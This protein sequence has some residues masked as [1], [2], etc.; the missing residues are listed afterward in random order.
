[1][2]NAYL[3][4][5]AAAA[6]A[7]LAAG[8]AMAADTVV[9]W[10]HIEHTERIV[11]NWEAVAEAFEKAH[12]GVD[13][14]LSFLENE[15]YKAKAPTLL[16]SNDRPHLIYSWGGGVM[17]EQADA[18]VIEDIT[19]VVGAQWQE[20]L[21]PAAVEAFTYKGRIWGGPMFVSQVGFWY[22]R[23]LFAK[24]GVDAEAIEDW[25]DLLAAVNTFKE[26]GITPISVGGGDKW[27]LHFYWT[28]L[29]MRTGGRDAFE[30]AV[31]CE[32]D[33]FAAEPFVRAGEL[34]QQLTELEPFQRG[35][36]A[37]KFQEA[38]GLF[39]DGNAA[40]HLM[41]NWDYNMQKT[42]SVSGKGL[43]D[44]RLGWF[45]FPQVEGGK[46]APGDTLGGVNGWLVTKGAPPETI[47]FLRFF[48][49]QENQRM[50]GREDFF[51]PVAVGAETDLKNPYYRRIAENIAASEYHQLFYDQMLGPDV[52][53]VVN[54]ISADL[55]TGAMTPQEAAET[56]QDAWSLDHC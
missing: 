39:G 36:V 8:P 14:Q 32:G 50:M 42:Q 51:I 35:Y 34:F 54:D 56:V 12:P 15:A 31:A 41:G 20:T 37:H 43:D 4:F 11:E 49:S 9:K 29:A 19:D 26:A 2:R 27:P 33:G 23:E 45:P 3:G 55:A 5:G 53:R 52:G 17:H 21:S 47:E 18:G 46:G 22:N 24:A 13:I 16:Q 44:E 28:H 48:L 40:M 25:D 30:Q 7:G 1:M 6:I 10:L 38:S